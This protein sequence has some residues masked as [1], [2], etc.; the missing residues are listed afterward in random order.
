MRETLKG[1]IYNIPYLCIM[2]RGGGSFHSRECKLVIIKF[3][4]LV[5][6][7]YLPNII[8]RN[9]KL[10]TRTFNLCKKLQLLSHV[11]RTSSLLRVFV[12]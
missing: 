2:W 9:S 10:A 5:L 8:I 3:F 12:E 1:I 4:F 11:A 6:F 7:V